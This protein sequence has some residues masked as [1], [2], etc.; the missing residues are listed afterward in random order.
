MKKLTLLLALIC[1]ASFSSSAVNKP[2]VREQASSRLFIGPMMCAD[3][4]FCG[5]WAT[6]CGRTPEERARVYAY[7]QASLCG[8]GTVNV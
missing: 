8:D 5:Q 7:A 3:F 6:V 2:T 4:L 1:S